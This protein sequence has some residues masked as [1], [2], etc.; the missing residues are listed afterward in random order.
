MGHHLPVGKY[1]NAA[2]NFSGFGIV[3]VVRND[4][5]RL[6]GFQDFFYPCRRHVDIDD[7][8]K[9]S[10]VSHAEKGVDAFHAFIHENSHRFFGKVHG[11]KGGSGFLGFFPYFTKSNFTFFVRK[12]GFIRVVT[13]CFLKVIRNGFPVHSLVPP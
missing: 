11:Q 7:G 4:G 8:I 12:R 1:L 10:A 9:I 3:A 2:G 5:F 6:Q 13:G